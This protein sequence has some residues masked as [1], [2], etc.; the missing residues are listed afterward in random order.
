MGQ[1]I[2]CET[3]SMGQWT[4][5]FL[6]AFLDLFRRLGSFRRQHPLGIVKF[7]LLTMPRQAIQSLAI[8]VNICRHESGSAVFEL[9][10][11]RQVS[12]SFECSRL[13]LS[14]GGVHVS[15]LNP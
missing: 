4:P 9:W 5:V 13:A 8:H 7:L 15:D 14:L 10:V 2:P 1:W 11:D 3:H 6:K 12:Y